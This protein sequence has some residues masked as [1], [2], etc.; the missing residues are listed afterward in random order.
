MNLFESIKAHFAGGNKTKPDDQ[1]INKADNA[2]AGEVNNE[3]PAKPIAEGIKNYEQLAKQIVEILKSETS[4]KTVKMK[5]TNREVGLTSSKFGGVPFIPK[6]GEY[7]TDVETSE[8]LSLLMQINFAEMPHI[9]D[10][11]TERTLL[12]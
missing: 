11:P 5:F 9:P 3:R 2:K 8:K 1:P 10:Y 12:C 7:P 6:G 4:K